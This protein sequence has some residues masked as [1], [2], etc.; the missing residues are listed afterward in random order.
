MK[1][2]FSLICLL[3]IGFLFNGHSQS[4]STDVMLEKIKTEGFENSQAMSMLGELT[5]VYGQ[6]LTGSN[7]YLA[8]AT[9]MSDKMTSLGLQN[10][11][12][13]SYCDDC[14][15]WSLE[16]F[17]VEMVSP[18]YMQISA[19]PLAMSKS[20]EG[21]VT[22]E[23][24]HIKGYK[25]LDSLKLQ[26]SG[27]LKDKI[28]LL[29]PIP[30]KKSLTDTLFQRYN[31]EDLNKMAKQASAEEEQTPLPELFESWETSDVREEGFLKFIEAEG[32]LAVLTSRSMYLG[33]LHPDGTYFYKNGQ[34]KPLPYF[35]IMPEHFGRLARMIALDVTPKIRLNLETSF[36]SKPEN[37]VNIIAELTGTD[38]KLKSETILVGAHF[39]SWHSGTGATDNG[40]NSIVLVEALR[41]LKNIGY[42]PKRTIKIGLW[43]G[44]EQAFL[45]SAA[46]AKKHY[47]RLDE[48]PNLESTKVSVYLNLD[49]GAG[50]IR[51]LYLQN[52]AF[53]KPVLKEVFSSIPDV[54]EGVL[55]IENTLSTDHETF[56]HYNIPSF[57]FIQDPLDY[58]SVTHH[59]QLDLLEYVPEQDVIKNAVIMAWTI[60]SL[61]ENKEK[62]PRKVL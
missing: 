25:H 38:K 17:H 9:W 3:F 34:L 32:A 48:K 7:E 50:A 21:L 35:T 20:T 29:G 55:T 24:V 43:G 8:A 13:E 49:N 40:A 31:D 28:I 6:R 11:H 53:A 14:R 2:K 58:Y 45:G 37:N 19:Y 42:K 27:K 36:Y 16:S 59:T 61:S 44:E 60:Y 4:V 41:I 57:Q 15:G 56:D 12:F 51:G 47:G 52:N 54:T 10:V 62:V 23:V 30:T 33:V 39:D 1:L 26:F 18:N 22:G 46:F 5:D